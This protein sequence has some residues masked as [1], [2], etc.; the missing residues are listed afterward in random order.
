MVKDAHN[1]NDGL[2]HYIPVFVAIIV[3]F[4]ATFGGNYLLVRDISPEVIAP[5]RFTGT[6]GRALEAR[7]TEL[8]RKVDKLPPV[9][10]RI[11][12]R[13]L[14]NDLNNLEERLDRL[15]EGHDYQLP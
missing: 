7:V 10:L 9:E 2:R 14:R 15:E 11:E 4:G 8:E 13:L 5:D 6:E 12:V 1:P 3:T